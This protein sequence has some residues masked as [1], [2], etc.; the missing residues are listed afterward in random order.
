MVCSSLNQ[1]DRNP[2]ASNWLERLR[3]IKRLRKRI[4]EEQARKNP[5]DDSIK[6]AL[7]EEDKLIIVDDLVQDFT[8]FTT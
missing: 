7:E 5:D 4:I 6:K 1:K 3:H 2:Y 8:D